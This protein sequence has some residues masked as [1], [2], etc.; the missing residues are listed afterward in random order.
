MRAIGYSLLLF[1]SLATATATAHLGF[2]WLATTNLLTGPDGIR[3]TRSTAYRLPSSSWL[4]F[5]V[6]EHGLIRVLSNCALGA[7]ERNAARYAVDYEMLDS[8]GR[9]ILSGRYHH[10]VH[11][12][13]LVA[14]NASDHTSPISKTSYAQSRNPGCNAA[15]FWIDA[16]DFSLPGMLRIRTAEQ[17][18][19]IVEIAARAYQRVELSPRKARFAWQRLSRRERERLARGFALSSEWLQPFE[20]TALAQ[21]SWRPLGPRGVEDQDYE[22]RVLLVVNDPGFERL[23]VTAQPLASQDPYR[24]SMD[25]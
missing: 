21:F 13:L 17:G 15:D 19:S 6:A 18:P 1:L 7:L 10:R 23:P 11:L 14:S 3:V 25:R 16:P 8:S 12:T 24:K 5:P 2:E 9:V 22:E 4:E 20:T